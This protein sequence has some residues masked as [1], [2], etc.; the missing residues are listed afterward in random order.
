MV[1]GGLLAAGSSALFTGKVIVAKLAYARGIDPLGLLTLRMVFAIPCYLIVLFYSLRHG[2]KIG[3]ADV[4]IS[5]IMGVMGYYLSSLLDFYAINHISTALERMILQLSPSLV[6]I[7]GILFLKERF[8]LK[9]LISMFVGY[10]GV[11][12]MVLS[13][14]NGAT[15]PSHAANLWVGVACMMGCILLFAFY[16]IGAERIMRRVDALPFTSIAMIGACLGICTHYSIARGLVLPTH[17]SGVLGLALIIALFCTVIPTFMAAVAIHKIGAAR[18]GPFNYVGMGLT[19][20]VSAFLVNES[21][22]VVKLVGIV[23]AVAGAML[24]TF[25]HK[26]ES[27]PK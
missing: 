5:L 11:G 8:D 15:S 1:V 20:V 4:V 21:F 24:L 10:I 14:M 2:R 17:D 3:R 19:F 18:T 9:L 23:L 12:F 7:I 6:M 22:P 16:S 13:E 25:C 26:R 27:S